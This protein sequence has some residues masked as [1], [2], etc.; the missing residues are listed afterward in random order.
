MAALNP[1]TPAPGTVPRYRA[2]LLRSALPEVC[3]IPDLALVLQVTP[4]S[5]RRLVQ[6]GALG[7]YGRLGRRIYCRRATLLTALAEREV[8]P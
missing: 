2:E 6:S 8:A 3:W 4:S 7:Q 5:A 1:A